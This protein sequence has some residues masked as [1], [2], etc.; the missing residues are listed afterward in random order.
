M[1]QMTVE[2][3]DELGATGIH[4]SGK[5]LTY[6]EIYGP[7]GKMGHYFSSTW[8][9]ADAMRGDLFQNHGGGIPADVIEK[10]VAA[11]EVM[12]SNA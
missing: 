8:L 3:L 4:I 2:V 7:G 12:G 11:S 10:L 1:W 5:D 6:L 9:T